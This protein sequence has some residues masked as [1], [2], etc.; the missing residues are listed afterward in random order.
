[1][2]VTKLEVLRVPVKGLLGAFKVSLADLFKQRIDGVEI[3]GNDLFFDT[4]KLLPAPRI[5]GTLTKV[6]IVSPDLEEV[7]GN[8]STDVERV[9]LW[10]N[11]LSLNGGAI[12]FGKLTM[13]N[14]DLIMIDISK[15]PWFDLDLVNYQA[16]LTGGYTRVTPQLGLQLFMPDL[17][18]VQPAKATQDTSIEWFKNRNIPPP[19]QITTNLH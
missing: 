14:V 2:H 5:R 16:Q 10:R 7:F 1:V 19:P 17:R 4:Q 9:E 15:D 3:T 13:N 11:F 8:A 12:N 18:D 6:H